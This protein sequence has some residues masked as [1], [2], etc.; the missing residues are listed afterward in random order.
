MEFS[1][2][3][4]EAEYVQAVHLGQKANSRS[5]LKVVM[6]WVF[7]LVCLM[8]LWGVV[9]KSKQRA[10]NADQQ[11]V[12]QPIEAHPAS[13]ETS[14]QK[15]L[16]NVGPF[17]LVGGIWTLLLAGGMRR[18]RRIYRK[19][20]LMQGQFTVNVSP[21]SISIQ[22]TAGTSSKTGWNIYKGW[23][24]G[25]GIIVLLLHPGTAFAMSLA[26]LSEPERNELRGV[27]TTA[28]PRK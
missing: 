13:Q 11:T 15:T 21:E 19:D 18:L 6:F 14:F 23:R 12:E 8:L 28:L 2:R 20:P 27:L 4:T 25:K 10:D 7:I 9:G 3:I 24:E 26:A 5:L 17:V 1:Y 22:N 16:I